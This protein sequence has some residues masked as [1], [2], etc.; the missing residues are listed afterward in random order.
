MR[1]HKLVQMPNIGGHFHAVPA[2]GGA[3]QDAED[4]LH[5]APLVHVL[6]HDFRAAPCITEGLRLLLGEGP[7]QEIGAANVTL[8]SQGIAKVGKAALKVI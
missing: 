4:Q 7:L 6:W 3:D 8:L 2:P 5:R 1:H